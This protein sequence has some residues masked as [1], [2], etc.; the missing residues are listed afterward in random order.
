MDLQ[1]WGRVLWR[2]RVLVAVGLAVAFLLAVLSFS[3]VG[4]DNGTPTLTYREPEE[5]V[6]YSTLFV[7]EKGFPWGKLST[8]G[9]SGVDPAR[10]ASLAVIYAQLAS[11]DDVR[12][13]M[14]REGPI[15][16]RIEAA[17]VTVGRD[18]ALPLVRIAGLAS[19]AEKARAIAARETAALRAYIAGQ[20]R[21]NTIRSGNRVM[22]QVVSRPSAGALYTARGKTRPIVVFLAVVIAF[23][24][25]AFALENVRPASREASGSTDG[26]VYDEPRSGPA[27]PSPPGTRGGEGGTLDRTPTRDTLRLSPELTKAKAAAAGQRPRASR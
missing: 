12:K 8:G 16:G 19:S 24:A 20:Q 17:A 27:D 18:D 7:T 5:W 25:L 11:S 23:C 26:V 6:S 3:K 9:T 21:T 10:L 15:D 14:L 22:L 1:L 4:F 2:F 13:L